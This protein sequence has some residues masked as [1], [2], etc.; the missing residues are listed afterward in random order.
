MAFEACNLEPSDYAQLISNQN[1][2]IKL[3]IVK[4]IAFNDPYSN[5]M[6]QEKFESGWGSLQTAAATPRAAMN[7]SLTEPAFTAFDQSCGLTGNTAQYGN[8]TY[9]ATPGVLSGNTN[10]ICVRQQYFAVERLLSQSIEMLKRGVTSIISADNRAN[11][12]NLSGTKFVVPTP[13]QSPMA[14]FTGS[15]WAVSTAFNGSLP[16]GQLT[17]AYAKWLY[18]TMKYDYE[19]EQFGEGADGHAVLITSQELND[20]LRN[21]APINNVLVASTTGSYKDGHDGLW[22]Y[23]FIDSN[24]RGLKLAIDPKPLRFNQIDG[25]GF[26]ILIEPYIQVATNASGYTWRT[27]G[28]WSNASYEVAFLL[29]KNAFARLTPENYSGEGEA[30]WPTGMFGGELKWNNIQDNSCNPWGDF[31]QFLYRVVRAVL[32]QAPHY[33][34]AILTKR[35]VGSFTTSTDVCPDYSDLT[36]N[37]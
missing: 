3:A 35:C 11:I 5:L 1:T 19:P 28:A 4:H 20:A 10:P 25:D 32:P 29:F 9:S 26:P 27:N 36:D 24:F 17:F 34:A 16:G 6:R 13:G 30:K 12:L 37:V 15:E 18:D 7:Q 31:G 22:K 14:G 8:Y 2:K 33:A 23:A 21:E